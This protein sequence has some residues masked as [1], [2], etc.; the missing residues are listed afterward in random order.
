MN[1]PHLISALAVLTAAAIPLSAAPAGADWPGW[2]GPT[3]DGQA[4]AGQTVPL[5]W[6][7]TE[8]VVWRSALPGKGHGSPTISGNRIYLAIGDTVPE[9][10][11]VICLERATGKIVWESVVHRGKVDET[12]ERNSSPASCTVAC[13]GE[14]LYINF[15]NDR[16]VHTSAL[17]LDGKVLWQRRVCGF[18]TVRGFGSSPVVHESVV[19]VSAD[20]KMGGK[21]AA[22][23][24]RTGE[25]VWEHDRPSLQNYSSPTLLSVG[26]QPQMFVAGCNLVASFEP[27]TGKKIWEV[28]G[29]TETTVTTPVSDGRRIYIT[30]GFPKSYVA[31]IEN[32]GSGQVVWQSGTGIYVPSLLVRAG[33]VYGLLDGGK[34]VC[35]NA[36][37]GDEL[38]REKVDRDFFAS[39]IM[40][41]ERIYA[42][43]VAG[44]TSVFAATPQKF[45]LLAQNN[46]GDEAYASPA[47][48]GNR[49]YLRHAKK[50]EPRQ[51]YLWCIGQ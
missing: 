24:K 40:S 4:V 32:D 12:G 8:N 10:Q 21:L 51:E 14:R 11:R 9:E 7:E 46:L 5:K 25:I 35:W 47:I 30:G 49:I 41:G 36:E 27:S 48:A 37:T 29:S 20:H 3:R 18:V 16:A 50:G 38:W 6:S 31:A 15:F 39:P 2:R 23:D 44:V 28:T 19:L 22:L 45:T 17:S 42:T 1:C 43:S 13:D 34:A 26:G 33:Y